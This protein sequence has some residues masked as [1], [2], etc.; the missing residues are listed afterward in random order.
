MVF[1]ELDGH[2]LVV[3]PVADL[4]LDQPWDHLWNLSPA[5]AVHLLHERLRQQGDLPEVVRH[6]LRPVQDL[7]VQLA[8]QEHD[9]RVGGGALPKRHERHQMVQEEP[10]PPL[11][12]QVVTSDVVQVVYGEKGQI[13]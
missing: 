6:E 1:C 13:S 12:P 10:R 3:G 4:I 5:E 7:V 11:E 9:G 8:E 2:H